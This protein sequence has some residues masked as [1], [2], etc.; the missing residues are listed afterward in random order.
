MRSFNGSVLMVLVCFVLIAAAL[1][2]ITTRTVPAPIVCIQDA[3]VT[4]DWNNNLIV[5]KMHE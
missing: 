5:E 4:Y 2:S 3:P 1:M